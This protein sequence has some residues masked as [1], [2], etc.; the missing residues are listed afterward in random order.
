MIYKILPTELILKI[1]DNLD[2]CSGYEFLRIN[3]KY[4]YLFMQK[5]TNVYKYDNL[6][7]VL[8]LII[9]VSC[10]EKKDIIIIKEN[11][12]KIYEEDINKIIITIPDDAS[13]LRL[14]I[15]LDDCKILINIENYNN[16]ELDYLISLTIFITDIPDVKYINYLDKIN[17]DDKY[18]DDI[19]IWEDIPNKDIIWI[20]SKKINVQYII[21]LLK[22]IDKYNNFK[23]VM[24][25]L[26]MCD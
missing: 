14:L 13:F 20:Y 15:I 4:K 3:K 21:K 24:D 10:I 16:Y 19:F 2:I 8:D 25:F 18:I 11:K 22:N 12:I 6:K 17:L 23:Y 1:Y 9:N 26:F 7:K 5:K